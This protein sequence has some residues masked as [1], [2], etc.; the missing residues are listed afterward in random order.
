MPR[1]SVGEFAIHLNGREFL[2]RPSFSALEKI[3]TPEEITDAFIKAQ[4]ANPEKPSLYDIIN[5]IIVMSACYVGNDDIYE[6]IGYTR[7]GK[8]SLPKFHYKHIPAH[9][10]IVLAKKLMTDGIVGKPKRKAKASDSGDS[11]DFSP[12]E[13]V[14]FAAKYFN[15]SMA[16][17][18]NLTM[19]EYQSRYDMEFPE[20][21]EDGMSE[22]KFKALQE[23][24]AKKRRVNNG[25]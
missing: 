7:D 25:R 1:L 8:N 12:L 15:I 2:F 19:I 14:S 18:W 23:R 20:E 4:L 21:K 9:D 17:A 3:G 11:S 10:L 6:L 24:V 5:A 13:F 16:E 22:D